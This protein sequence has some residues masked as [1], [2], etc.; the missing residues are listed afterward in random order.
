MVTMTLGENTVEYDQAGTG[1]DIVL[2]PTLLAE[3]SV[4]DEVI[5]DLDALG[6][7]HIVIPPR[8][9]RKS[10]LWICNGDVREGHVMSVGL[11]TI[12]PPY[13]VA[14]VEGDRRVVIGN[15]PGLRQIRAR[16]RVFVVVQ[17]CHE[18]D[19]LL[20]LSRRVI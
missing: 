6:A 17:E 5:D 15:V 9:I 14:E 10:G 11:F 16:H 18:I 2:L 19:E 3:M 20:V 1:P 13:V 4:Y 12:V 8:R 7:L